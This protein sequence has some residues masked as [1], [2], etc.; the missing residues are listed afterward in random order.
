MKEVSWNKYYFF[1]SIIL[2]I[3]TVSLFLF[4]RD[5]P[6]YKTHNA[7]NQQQIHLLLNDQALLLQDIQSKLSAQST[8]QTE[9]KSRGGQLYF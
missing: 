8:I 7:S 4:F 9:T 5:S 1:F 6:S 3:C 2:N